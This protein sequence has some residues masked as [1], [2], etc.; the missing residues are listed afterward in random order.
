MKK[1]TTFNVSYIEKSRKKTSLIYS[2]SSSVGR[3]YKGHRTPSKHAEMVCISSTKMKGTL[4]SLSFNI[5][6][7]RITL[8]NGMPCHHCAMHLKKKGYRAIK[9]S[10]SNRKIVK[11][12]ID[13][14]LKMT[15]VSVG[16]LKLYPQYNFPNIHIASRRTFNFIRTGDKK[17]E[18]RMSSPFIS[19]ISSN[20]TIYF[21]W[22]RE[23][24]VARVNLIRIKNNFNN[25]F[26]REN[27]TDIL[28]HLKNIPKNKR[29]KMALTYYKKLYPRQKRRYVIVFFFTLVCS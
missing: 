21:S 13:D 27:I 5:S 20:S 28:P 17:I 4:V 22:Q 25:L 2:S 9:Y 29:K 11:R 15:H 19:S 18:V 26:K 23:K 16:Y 3:D 1:N 10:D 8:E 14:I 24:V 7:D 12:T 6:S